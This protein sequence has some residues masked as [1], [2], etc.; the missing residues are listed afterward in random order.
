VVALLTDDELVAAH[1]DFLQQYGYELT[2]GA[3]ENSEWTC[4][5]SLHIN[6]NLQ[7][8]GVVRTSLNLM[9]DEIESRRTAT[10]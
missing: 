4:G 3:L 2:L 7:C 10:E 6:G 1:N 8:I 5:G 9:W